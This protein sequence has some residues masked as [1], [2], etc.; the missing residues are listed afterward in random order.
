VAY[1]LVQVRSPAF[2]PPSGRIRALIWRIV[3]M[4]GRELKDR[5]AGKISRSPIIFRPCAS[6]IERQIDKPIPKPAGLVV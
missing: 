5:A 3:L 4:Q 2:G 1:A 6:V